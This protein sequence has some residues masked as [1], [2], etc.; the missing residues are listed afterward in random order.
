M[1][2]DCDRLAY[3]GEAY[4]RLSNEVDHKVRAKNG[5][6]DDDSPSNLWALCSY[7]HKQK[8]ARESGEARVEKR[9]SREEAEW[10]SRPAFR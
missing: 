6:P 2:V 7:H 4:L 9:R 8:T 5:E 1:P 3:G 10:Y